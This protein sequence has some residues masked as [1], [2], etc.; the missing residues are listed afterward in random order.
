M[1][2]TSVMAAMLVV[3]ILMIFCVPFD[4]LRFVFVAAAAFFC[5]GLSNQILESVKDGRE[6]EILR[7]EK[8]LQSGQD[9]LKSSLDEIVE[10]MADREEK[11]SRLLN[12]MSVQHTEH[13]VQVIEKLLEHL[14]EHAERVTLAL[15]KEAGYCASVEEQV[16]VIKTVMEINI[17]KLIDLTDN[18]YEK[19][20]EL[21]DDQNDNIEESLESL[22]KGQLQ[23]L[24]E[25]S[26]RMEKQIDELRKN[27]WE[28]L[29]PVLAQ[30]EALLDYIQKVQK[31]WTELD[32]EEL[33]FL[34]RV[35]RER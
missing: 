10:Q 19:M 11:M 15:E 30:N 23:L 35:W 14:P 25:N 7:I 20:N 24:K 33:K 31:E 21:F 28:G 2:E 5:Y 26:D 12:D 22:K 13:C 29:Q 32:R 1:K 16:R 9:Q 3:S 27:I 6:K 18:H 34:D 8:L 4:L 17:K